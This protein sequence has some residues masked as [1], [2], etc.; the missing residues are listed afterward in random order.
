MSSSVEGFD[1]LIE[2]LDSL[3]Q[4][5][6]RYANKALRDG[7]KVIV[8]MQKKDAPRHKG[9]PANGKSSHGADN[10]KIGSVK[11]AKG[12]KNK[13][14]QIGIPDS[15]TWYA[16][17]GIYFQ[18]HG[19]FNKRTNRYHAGSL[20]MDKSFNKAKGT[21]TKVLISALERGLKL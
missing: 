11:T 16:A 19:F 4:A 9:G 21:A 14:V 3:G 7:A 1:K 12:S 5:G 8:N 2:K 17:Q 10:L 6:N 15:G 20:W 18:H 13:Y